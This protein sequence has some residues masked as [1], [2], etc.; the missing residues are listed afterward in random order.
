MTERDLLRKLIAGESITSGGF[1]LGNPHPETWELFHRYF[2]TGGEEELRRLLGDGFRWTSPQFFPSTFKA[3]GRDKPFPFDDKDFLGQDGPFSL[4]VDPARVNDFDWP[5]PP[6]LD[7]EESLRDLKGVGEY[8]RASGFWAPFFHDVMDLFGME[9]YLSKMYTHPQVVHAVTDR[10]CQFYYS[11]NEAFFDRAGDEIDGFFFG[12]D[13]GTQEDLI[14]HPELFEEFLL[15]WIRRFVDQ[16]KGRGYQVILHSC[17]SIERVI[18]SLIHAGVDCLHPIQAKAR[19]MDAETLSNRYRGRI[20]FLGGIDTQDVLVNSSPAEVR[21]EVRRVKSL[22]GPSLIVSPSHE[23][24]LP[25]IPP[26]NIEA[27]AQEAGC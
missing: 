2:G 11:A 8:Y 26:E 15:P 23:A 22:L 6:L 10:V 24:L 27:M 14:V 3:L 20:S 21:E 17:G 7:F 16:A 18:D 19:G 9:S 25:N 12:N 1:W 5:S 13:F 4:C